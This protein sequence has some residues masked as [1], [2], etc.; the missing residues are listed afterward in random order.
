MKRRKFFVPI[1]GTSIID[2]YK[3]NS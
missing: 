1:I 2:K 3:Y